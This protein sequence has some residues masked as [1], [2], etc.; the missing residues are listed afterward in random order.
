MAGFGSMSI[1]FNGLNDERQFPVDQ[2][3]RAPSQLDSIDVF[4]ALFGLAS[5]WRSV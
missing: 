4:I 2:E 1:H 5:V 3:P